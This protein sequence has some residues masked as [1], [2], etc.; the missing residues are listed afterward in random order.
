MAETDPQLDTGPIAKPRDPDLQAQKDKCTTEQF[1]F[2]A[3]VLGMHAFLLQWSVVLRG[4]LAIAPIAQ[5]S[6]VSLWAACLVIGRAKTYRRLA[7][8]ETPKLE[9]S[10]FSNGAGFTCF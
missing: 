6:V 2:V 7:K 10:D 3:T 9:L 5:S 4:W 8:P 1:W